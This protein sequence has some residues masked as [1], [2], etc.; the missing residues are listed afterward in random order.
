MKYFIYFITLLLVGCSPK[1]D[2][3]PIPSNGKIV[4]LENFQSKYVSPR[5]IDIWLP[6]GYSPE[7]K[8]AALYMH[9]G[10]MLYD[11]TKTW[12]GQEWRIDEVLSQLIDEK[13]V[14]ECIVV[15]IWNDKAKRYADFFPQKALNY[16]KSK[17]AE[18][19]VR[20]LFNGEPL[21]DNYLH[22]IVNEVK[23]YIDKNYNTYTD[24]KNT[25]I[26]GSS[27]GGLISIYAICEYPQVFGGAA[28]LSTHWVGDLK[29][30]FKE[31]PQA[32][33]SYLLE[34]L[35]DPL[36]HKIYFDYGT[37]T[38]DSLYK[39]SQQM[40]DG[41]MKLK[42]YNE[43]NWRTIEFKGDDHSERSWSKRLNIPLSFLLATDNK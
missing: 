19:L 27:M 38:V 7:K 11:S 22:F 10:Q 41:T 30:S 36:T 8:Y 32:I 3:T 31:I 40:V 6:D 15:G 24:P 29:A 42:G 21:A 35:P 5:N 37:K 13:K 20:N 34:N 4:R 28:C 16:I 43:I 23:P 17:E 39:P 1:K 26:M 12:N 9:D 25:Y 33:N 18:D 14:K 2:S